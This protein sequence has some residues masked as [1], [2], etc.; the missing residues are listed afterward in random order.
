M[1]E[2]PDGNFGEITTGKEAFDKA[3]ELF[4]HGQ[5]VK[6]IHFG[7]AEELEAKKEEKSLEE[8][9]SE[10]VSRVRKL[11]PTVSENIIIPS[12][13]DIVTFG[14]ATNKEKA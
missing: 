11:E 12:V 7:T 5:S 10:L 3:L 2:Y 8:K 4:Q 14:A 9:F 13:Q 1:L 6:A